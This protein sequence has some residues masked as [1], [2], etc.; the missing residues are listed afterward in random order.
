EPDETFNFT[1]SNA[2]N[3]TVS[4]SVSGHG[5]IVNDDLTVSVSDAAPVTE[6]NSG[7]TPATFTISLSAP[8]SH[9]VTVGYYTSGGTATSGSDY[10]MPNGLATFNPGQTSVTV[11]VPVIGDSAYE[12]NETFS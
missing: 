9:V 7:T 2:V 1:L 3:A 5:T 6:G 12:G 4:T 10:V 11:A 8:S